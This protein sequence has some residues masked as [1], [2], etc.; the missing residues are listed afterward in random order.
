MKVVCP[1]CNKEYSSLSIHVVKKHNISL[2]EFLELY[3]GV[4][5]S[6]DELSKRKSEIMSE[7][8]KNDW[9]DEDYRKKHSEISRQSGIKTMSDNSNRFRLKN[10]ELSHE[11]RSRA[12]SNR[13]KTVWNNEN[14]RNQMKE[15]CKNG[16]IKCQELHKEELRK[17]NS[18]ILKNRWD[19]DEEF[20]RKMSEI[21]SRTMSSTMNRLWKDEYEFMH[22]LVC[23]SN[24]ERGFNH[25][26]Y[27]NND[28]NSTWEVYF[29]KL[30]DSNNI[31]CER[32]QRQYEFTYY[33]N[34]KKKT[35]RPDFFL[36]EYNL[37]IEIKANYLVDEIVKLKL[38]SV[39]SC[40]NDIYLITE[41]NLWNDNLIYLI[42]NKLYASM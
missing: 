41:D 7:R 15:V 26:K 18:E 27:N 9:K 8:N 33:V 23:E 40:D 30:C 38:E 6:S 20:R 10:Y 14:Y 16:G 35:Y 4:K 22:D 5:M 34:D 11:E 28:Y 29:Q 13:N 19:N 31:L 17:R 2:N 37:F 21:S 36:P 3:P 42:T 25:Y 24:Y 12:V 39:R 32:N 1:I